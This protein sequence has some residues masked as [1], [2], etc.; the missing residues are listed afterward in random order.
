VYAQERYQLSYWDAL[1]VVTAQLAGCNC[2]YAEDLA[3]GRMYDGLRV[4]DPF[5]LDPQPREKAQ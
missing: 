4:A 5:S 1:I 2:L 3:E